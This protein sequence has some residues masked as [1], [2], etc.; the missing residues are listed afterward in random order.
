MMRTRAEAYN[1]LA[2]VF[3]FPLYFGQNLM[4]VE[5]FLTDLEW[6]SPSRGWIVPI[7]RPELF[8]SDDGCADA[9]FPLVAQVFMEAKKYWAGAIRYDSSPAT[10]NLAFNVVLAASDEPD[11]V[12]AR[13]SGAGVRIIRMGSLT[14]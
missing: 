2:A 13:W 1:E 4:A 7:A 5:D 8:L 9:D 12:A 11:K 6:T 14:P 10:P 3:Q